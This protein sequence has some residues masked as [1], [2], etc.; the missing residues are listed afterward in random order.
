MEELLKVSKKQ[1]QF[2]KVIACCLVLIAVV[3]GAVGFS[4]VGQ[5]SRMTTALEEA[6]AK[7][8]GIDVEG[9]NASVR[10][11]Q[12]LMESVGEFS[13]A[14]DSVTDKVGKLDNWFSGFLGAGGR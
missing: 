11:T 3:L 8:A 2:Q 12:K 7:I 6:T 9:I 5:V 10:E 14:V 1:L 13:D 4:F